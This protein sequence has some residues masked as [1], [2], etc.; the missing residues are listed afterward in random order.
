MKKKTNID[1][2]NQTIINNQQNLQNGKQPDVKKPTT[3]I[4]F[5]RQI[6][7]AGH[8]LFIA[9]VAYFHRHLQ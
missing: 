2:S 9:G 7:K 6:T 5:L 3:E 8:R 4:L 1:E